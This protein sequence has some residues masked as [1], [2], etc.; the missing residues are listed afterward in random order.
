MRMTARSGARVV[1][2]TLHDSQAD[3]RVIHLAQR[4]VVPAIGAG[5]DE[6]RHI[7][8]CEGG[9]LDVEIGRVFL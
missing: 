2:F 1:V 7:D 5:T 8:P 4:L 3:D 6:R 9:E